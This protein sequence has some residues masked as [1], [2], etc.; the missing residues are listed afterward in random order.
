M[1]LLFA[2]SFITK[3]KVFPILINKLIFLSESIFIPLLVFSRITV[4]SYNPPS[5]RSLLLI[6]AGFVKLT[7]TG[8]FFDKCCCCSL[9]V[10]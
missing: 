4:I 1:L 7:W 9:F 10:I 8:S 3:G 5:E 2:D 6:V